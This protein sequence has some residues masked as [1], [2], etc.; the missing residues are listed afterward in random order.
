MPIT[1]CP[2]TLSTPLQAEPGRERGVYSW[3]LDTARYPTP[4][5]A[6]LLQLPDVPRLVH[7]SGRAELL[8]VG[9]AR[10]NLH[11]R[12]VGQHLRRTRSSALRRTLLAVL[13]PGGP[14]W[15]Q[16][17]ALDGRGRV[18]LDEAQEQRLTDWIQEH[19]LLGW[20]VCATKDDVD[21]LERRWIA[22][23]RPV[24][25]TDGTDHGAQLTALKETFRAG[26]PRRS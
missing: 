21:A 20:A 25:N 9:R 22:E 12:I 2:L 15:R 19:L 13:L 16:G 6:G 14:S 1:S 24:L 17:A 10:R 11:Q 4:E 3:W 26:L 8:Y 7:A 18:V 5:A 23:H